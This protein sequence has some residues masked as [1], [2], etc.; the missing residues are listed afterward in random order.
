M[1]KDIMEERFEDWRRRETIPG[2][3]GGVR[4]ASVACGKSSS[5]SKLFFKI[6]NDFKEVINICM[7]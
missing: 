1:E 2:K 6:N 3:H 7:W 4:A 5:N